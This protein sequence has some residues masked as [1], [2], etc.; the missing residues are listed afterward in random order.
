MG[1]TTNHK[2]LKTGQQAKPKCVFLIWI[3]KWFLSPHSQSYL[4]QIF[5]ATTQFFK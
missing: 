5:Y 2:Y 1:T 4:E 3:L